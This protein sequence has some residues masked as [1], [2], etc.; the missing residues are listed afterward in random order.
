[1]T[2]MITAQREA[3]PP[4]VDVGTRANNAGACRP[5][6]LECEEERAV[7]YLQTAKPLCLETTILGVSF[8]HI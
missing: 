4:S 1:M 8:R 6:L 7:A 2:H 3:R 5:Q